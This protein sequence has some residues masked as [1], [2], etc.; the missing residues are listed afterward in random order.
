MWFHCRD[1]CI[2]YL[3][4]SLLFFFIFISFSSSFYFFFVDILNRNSPETVLLWDPQTLEIIFGDILQHIETVSRNTCLV[5]F[6]SFWKH[7]CVEFS[8]G[9]QLG[10]SERWRFR[11]L[12][13]RVQRTMCGHSWTTGNSV[14]ERSIRHPYETMT[15]FFAR[16]E[17]LFVDR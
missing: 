13:D 17:F 10:N 9:I 4:W 6:L 11:F 15:M 7:L 12:V 1:S 3:F 2:V 5:C 8:W 16:K 14:G